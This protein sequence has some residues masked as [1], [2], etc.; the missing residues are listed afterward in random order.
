MRVGVVALVALAASAHATCPNDCNG[1]GYCDGGA[2]ELCRCED[3]WADAPDCSRRACA[4]RA[5][6]R[7]PL[8]PSPSWSKRSASASAAEGKGHGTPLR[9]GVA[10][11]AL[12]RASNATVDRP[13]SSPARVGPACQRTR[14]TA[15]HC[16]YHTLTRVP[17]VDLLSCRRVPAGDVV[18][19][20]PAAGR[21]GPQAGHL[22]QPR[23]LRR[24]ARAV[25]VRGRIRRP[26]L[27]AQ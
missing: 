11:V 2:K 16:Q 4:R 5:A 24:A 6:Q 9:P 1:R 8:L 26:R 14:S 21:L 17:S 18:V 12:G 7:A 23:P 27:P 3:A 20:L 22:L 10:V 19:R 25:R 15:A 13:A